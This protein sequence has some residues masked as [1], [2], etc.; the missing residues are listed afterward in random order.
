MITRGITARVVVAV[1]VESQRCGIAE[2]S[3]PQRF[4][5]Q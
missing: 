3:A 2:R 1:V 4:D 5:S